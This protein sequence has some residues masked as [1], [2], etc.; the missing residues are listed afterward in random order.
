VLKKDN[1]LLREEG[2]EAW[3]KLQDERRAQGVTYSDF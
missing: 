1:A 2:M 3:M